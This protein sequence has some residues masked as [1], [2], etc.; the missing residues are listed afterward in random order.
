[1]K[2]RTLVAKVNQ[3]HSLSEGLIAVQEQLLQVPEPQLNT[4][5]QDGNEDDDLRVDTDSPV[6]TQQR[7]YRHK[8][9]Y[10]LIQ[11]VC[12]RFNSICMVFTRL[13]QLK[14]A[15][16]ELSLKDDALTNLIFTDDEWE[17][18]SQYNL[19]LTEVK[20]VCDLW[21]TSTVPS[22]SLVVAS[23][24]LLL[25]AFDDI[26]SKMTHV[27]CNR[28]LKAV[29]RNIRERWS[30]SLS[31]PAAHMAMLLDPRFKSKDIPGYNWNQGT[32]VL[33]HFYDSFSYTQY[34]CDEESTRPEEAT[35]VESS[36]DDPS[37]SDDLV[38]L[39]DQ[40]GPSQHRRSGSSLPSSC[41]KRR[42]DT[43]KERIQEIELTEMQKYLRSGGIG[44]RECPLQWWKV[45]QESFPKLCRL[46][47]IYLAIP[48]S[49]ASSERV[50]SR[51]GLELT[52]TRKRLAPDRLSRLVF[53]KSNMKL[54]Q[55]LKELRS[56]S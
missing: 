56:R 48:A 26:R 31:T 41:K 1:M 8:R 19:V 11:D 22:L 23:I 12:T 40:D 13:L 49:S 20:E 25:F 18:M 17:Q 3:S 43:L 5:D 9:V 36:S 27:P 32:A 24:Y 47:R 16:E 2:A 39:S 35:V 34:C 37:N 29:D 42:L 38:A 50:F 52:D 6:A 45:H 55:E 28:M 54:Y 4:I 33:E 30:L 10:R 44:L 14:P 46:A 7:A 53:L 21:E 15:L 51:A